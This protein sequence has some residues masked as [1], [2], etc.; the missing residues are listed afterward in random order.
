MTIERIQPALGEALPL[1]GALALTM[2]LIACARP[3]TGPAALGPTAV[4]PTPA[5]VPAPEPLPAA[6]V[7][8]QTID[9]E[10]YCSGHVEP[11][12]AW[13]IEGEWREEHLSC[14]RE[15]P[16]AGRVFIGYTD[17]ATIDA[18]LA[19]GLEITELEVKLHRREQLR[20]LVEL[21]AL[22]SLTLDVDR[23]PTHGPESLGVRPAV[24]TVDDFR[25]LQRL[26]K[27]RELSTMY[28]PVDDE[29]LAVLGTMSRL[30]S[31]VVS[32][33]GLTSSSLKSLRPLQ[34]LKSL[35]IG[36]LTTVD[37]LT[38]FDDE[39]FL[40][41]SHL[42]ELKLDEVA[43]D[44]ALTD[45][46]LE[47]LSR[48]DHWKQLDLRSTHVTAAGLASIAHWRLQSLDLSSTK[49]SGAALKH[50][51]AIGTLEE[52]TLART[53]IG[54]ADLAPLTKLVALR[55]LDLGHTAVD[56]G[57]VAHLSQMGELRSLDLTGTKVGQATLEALSS[58]TQLRR[59][60]L[61][62]TSIGAGAGTHLAKLRQLERLDLSDTR[63]GDA[64]LA[65]LAGMRGLK[66]LELRGVAVGSGL[67]HVPSSTRFI[68]LRE[69]PNLTAAHLQL[70]QLTEGAVLVDDR[71]DLAAAAEKMN[72]AN[73]KVII[74][75]R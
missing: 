45:R 47:L 1:A 28:A 40:H 5:P 8:P 9:G 59:I 68:N 30:E 19:N 24:F 70:L 3:S 22:E 43:I 63:I 27:L 67:E 65:S 50:I 61:G 74:L 73:P 25:L 20:A 15:R 11:T 18:V 41:L 62:G 72:A 6:Q 4:P 36:H 55:R 12:G 44:D 71:A 23:G 29:K 39:A 14:L 66:R 26:P 48:Y 31:L 56:D 60:V 58:L 46:G 64:D 13:L 21:P 38:H 7:V 33:V 69:N 16:L 35:H 53:N 37:S 51:G 42:P 52:L 17:A 57:A 34:K 54:S 75:P 2:S 49:V 32:G 10:T